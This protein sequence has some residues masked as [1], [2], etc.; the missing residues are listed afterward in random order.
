MHT[1][2]E[3]Y[4]ALARHHT[5][6]EGLNSCGTSDN[7][8]PT[9]AAAF[10]AHSSAK[11]NPCVANPLTR[12]SPATLLKPRQR[13]DRGGGA[14]RG[15]RGRLLWV[16]LG[17][18][19]GQ[20]SAGGG[21]AWVVIWCGVVKQGSV[22]T[23][24]WLSNSRAVR[25]GLGRALAKARVCTTHALAIPDRLSP[26]GPKSPIDKPSSRSSL[27]NGTL[28]FAGKLLKLIIT[29]AFA[30]RGHATENRTARGRGGK[31]EM[32]E[33]RAGG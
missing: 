27:M 12:G 31:W 33:V 32:S 8:D 5:C 16:W 22:S 18:G 9:A 4:R 21:V 13:N 23:K 11:D 28:S 24:M 25:P 26:S 15:R 30:K 6:G 17:I 7:A 3:C 19:Q 1:L 2:V 10:G 29:F 14:G 20:R